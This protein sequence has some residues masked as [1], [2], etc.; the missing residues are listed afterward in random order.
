MSILDVSIAV[1]F[2]NQSYFSR[3]F[4]HIYFKIISIYYK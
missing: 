4:K 3:L 1:S 2:N